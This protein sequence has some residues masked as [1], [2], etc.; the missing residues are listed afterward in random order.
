MITGSLLGVPISFAQLI[1]SLFS[2]LIL[3]RKISE[4]ASFKALIIMG[5]ILG[6]SFMEFLRAVI[7]LL[8][9]SLWLLP[10]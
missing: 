3:Q 8:V 2:K 7:F 1:G 10:Y 6:D 9:R 4:W 5:F